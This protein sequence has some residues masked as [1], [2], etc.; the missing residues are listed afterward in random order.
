MVGRPRHWVGAAIHQWESLSPPLI[1]D[2]M[3]ARFQAVPANLAPFM[4]IT[5]LMQPAS[6]SLVYSNLLVYVRSPRTAASNDD[7]K[8][9]KGVRSADTQCVGLIVC[10]CRCMPCTPGVAA[11]CLH[12]ILG[13][14][15]HSRQL[16]L[17]LRMCS[18]NRTSVALD[19]CSVC[20]GHTSIFLALLSCSSRS[21][22]CVQLVI[23]TAQAPIYF[24]KCT[25][26]GCA[27]ARGIQV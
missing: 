10:I 1:I 6:T 13:H 18:C 3:G 20:G 24:A 21:P 25:R 14:Q 7:L 27:C 12:L 23:G 4:L 9:L 15:L 22:S 26:G 19:G 5:L 8:H 16:E 11:T 2:V 17:E